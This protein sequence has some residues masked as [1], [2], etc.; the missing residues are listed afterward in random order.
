MRD[1]QLQN[2]LLHFNWFNASIESSRGMACADAFRSRVSA[3][4]IAKVRWA[5][6][7]VAFPPL[8]FGDSS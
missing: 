2:A 7:L 4:P 3:F 5:A 1:F 6:W 8:T